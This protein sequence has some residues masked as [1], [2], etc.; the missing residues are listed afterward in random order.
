MD[1]FFGIEIARKALQTSQYGLDV[2][3][4]NIANANTPGYSRQRVIQGTTESFPAPSWN[5]PL[6]Q[7]QLGTGVE[8][9]TIQRM[10]DD[11]FDGQL[12]R[13]NQSMGEWEVKGNALQ[14]LETVFNEPSDA[15]LLNILGEFWGSWQQL[16]K[17]PEG[18]SARSAVLEMGQTLSTTFRQITEKMSRVQDNLNEQ[19]KVKVDEINGT[20]QRISALN[21]DILHVRTF[22]AEPN[23]L[24]DERD[25]LIDQLSKMVDIQL[26]TLDNGT[27]L[28]SVNGVQ[29]VGDHS[30]SELKVVANGLNHGFYDVKWA[31]D[32]SNITMF[33]GELKALVTTRDVTVLKYKDDLDV[34]AGE[35]ISE[36]NFAHRAGFSLDG[37]TTGL[38]FFSGTNASDIALDVTNPRD[39]AA[40]QS[41]APGDGSNALAIAQLKDALIMSG[42]TITT[43]DYY[44]SIITGLGIESLEASRM[45]ANGKLYYDLIENHRQSVSGV[46]LDEEATNMIKYQRA[47][48]AAARVISVFD[49]MLDVLINQMAR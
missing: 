17:N 9:K 47:Y 15:G 14:Q 1:G 41:G 48:Q 38:D 23:D 8:V 20:A 6:I 46:S 31:I 24:M 16:S 35:L 4:H 21:K 26:N 5:R 37:V 43:G 13:E 12:R 40:S 22:G 28:V 42:D 32:N 18:L 34:L 3:A 25:L 33:G 44:R 11:F 19:V 49:E 29:L 7:G 30:V 45:V 2:T 39:V 10:R 36:I 27:V